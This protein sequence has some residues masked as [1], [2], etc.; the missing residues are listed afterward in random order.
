MVM[1]QSLAMNIF[2]LIAKYLSSEQS[3]VLVSIIEKKGIAPRSNAR[4]L[5]FPDGSHYDT[6]GGGEFES[7]VIA[8]ALVLYDTHESHIKQIGNTSLYFEYLAEEYLIDFFKKAGN[9]AEKHLA[10]TLGTVLGQSPSKALLCRNKFFYATPTGLVSAKTMRDLLQSATRPCC[11]EKVFVDIVGERDHLLILGGGNVS[12]SLAKVA[13]EAGYAYSVVETR[14]EFATRN[15]YPHATQREVNQ[16]I[17]QAL[18]RITIDEH[19]Y[20]VITRNALDIHIVRMLQETQTPYIGIL[21]S[22]SKM[23]NYQGDKLYC[24]VGL[25]LGG[26][27]PQMIAISILSEIMKIAHGKSARSLKEQNGLIIIR[28]AG[29]LATGVIVRLH[30][31]GYPVL[32]LEMESP[33]VIRRTV[34]LAEAMYEQSFTVE[35]VMA[36]RIGCLDEVYPVISKGMIPVLSDQEARSIAILK[37]LVVIDAILAKRNLGTS[38]DD[39]PLVIALGPGFYAGK[40]C[41]V[42][43]ETMRG[44]NLGK[45]IIDGAALPDTSTPGQIA[46]F[47]KERVIHSPCSGVFTHA[48]HEIG[49]LIKQGDIIA[50]CG[51]IALEATIDGMLRGLLREGLSIPQG[52]K[53]ADIDPRGKDAIFTTCSDKAKAIA[54]SVLETVDHFKSTHQR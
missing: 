22:K 14:E 7:K 38:I 41:H 15:L 28:G 35:G 10:F 54:G 11:K 50:Y 24:P 36:K 8:E 30:N 51:T 43:I 21:A 6:I 39:A 25:D 12:Q 31:A 34:S 1:I 33:T 37:P 44:H 13:Y 16:S 9:L 4:M 26:E 40:D 20:V 19:T 49:S 3:T 42:V 18:S 47:G 27:T 32:A 17:A 53:V 45:I 29:D 48:G 46:N 52:F 2:K 23:G 5:V